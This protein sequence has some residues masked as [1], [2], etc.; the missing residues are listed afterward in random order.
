MDA[1]STDGVFKRNY[2]QASS[3]SS[4]VAL[5]KILEGRATRQSDNDWM[6]SPG[7]C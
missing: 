1:F 2:S 3:G 7:G 6:S 4:E 5:E